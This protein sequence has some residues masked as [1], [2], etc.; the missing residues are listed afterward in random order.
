M[1][2]SDNAVHMAKAIE[3]FKRYPVVGL[4]IIVGVV[5]LI[6]YFSGAHQA[7]QIVIT[8]FV[9]AFCV[10]T[11]IDMVRDMIRGH[12][13]LDILALVA[14]VST[15]IV[16]E[17]WAS[18]VI[19]LM[20]SGGEAL[21]DF[22][23]NRA[24][25]ELTSLLDRSPSEAHVIRGKDTV[26]I[27]VDD[28]KVGD[29][30]LVRPSEVVPVDGKM[31]S[32]HGT[33]DESSITG[34]SLPVNVVS[35]D[36][37][38]SGATNGAEAVTIEAVRE[39]AD[40]QYQKI[41][42]LV[43]EAQDSKAPVVRVADRFAVPFTVISLII[44]GVAWWISGNPVR[45]AEVLVLATPCPLLIAAP[46]A[47]MGGMS[48]SAKAGIVVKG[49]AAL[50]QAARI[51]SVAMDKTGTI[52][53]GRPV[54]LDVRPNSLSAQELLALAASAEQ[55]STHVL[56]EGI[57][58][59]A[60]EQGLQLPAVTSA[61]ELAAKGIE[62]QLGQKTVRVGQLSFIQDVAP[63]ATVAELSAGEVATYVAYGDRFVGTIILGDQIRPEAASV[64][65]WLK[66][67]G[68]SD[69]EMLTGDAGAAAHDVASQTGITSVRYNLKPADKARIV[70]ELQPKPTL[71]VG[72][73]IND[74][75]VLAAANVGVAM[76]AKG[77]TAAGQAADAV[78]LKDSLIPLVYFVSIAKHTLNVALSSV[79][80]GVIASIILMLIATTGV[81]PAII[82][83]LI[84]E[85]LDLVAIL[86]A[87]RALGGKLP[88][89]TV[90]GNE[91]EVINA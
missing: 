90:V 32:Q 8:V 55:Y 21:E 7:A 25:R 42:R 38:P 46:V 87:L 73:G 86:F 1:E 16:G 26:D 29:H 44:A 47:F 57:R 62:A 40:S 89:V 49:G 78:I 91:K 61:R 67:A 5:G 69:V 17:Y 15:L 39:S 50:E 33:F 58:Q 81:I 6:I 79:W 82:G 27:P 45:F 9:G 18:I 68:V 65:S 71:M 13:G 20:L 54:V 75:P 63:D 11:A 74:A 70:K 59:A 31:L 77:A 3:F 66:S 10:W 24:Q 28:V 14:M 35:G 83:A 51:H 88:E 48:R 4:A 76:G 80:V 22:A 19:V 64:V 43:Q 41:I 84:Q 12:F 85:V 56:A 36:E 52:T 60:E 23:A 30:L 53:E 34:E 72:D 2:Q 37:I